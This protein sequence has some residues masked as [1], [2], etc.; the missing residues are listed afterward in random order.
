MKIIGRKQ[1]PTSKIR[2]MVL[3]ITST[4]PFILTNGQTMRLQE[5]PKQC[6]NS[7]EL[8]ILLYRRFDNGF[9]NC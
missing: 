9:L 6:L 8:A 1:S 2:I 7:T 5:D 3:S 4:T